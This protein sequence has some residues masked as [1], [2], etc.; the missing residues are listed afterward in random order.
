VIKESIGRGNAKED[1]KEVFE[2]FRS[3]GKPDMLGEGR[4]LPV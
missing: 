1:G 3:A 2:L 4:A